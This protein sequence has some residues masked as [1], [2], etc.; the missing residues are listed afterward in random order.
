MKRPP[1][2]SARVRARA[3]ALAGGALALLA[4]VAVV[5]VWRSLLQRSEAAAARAELLRQVA[6]ATE[7]A[8]PEPGELSRLAALLAQEPER[9]E[10][11]DLLAAA[12][13]IELARQR[14]E[15]A[16]AL[17]G[18]RAATPGASP[19][20]QGLGAEILLQ[21]QQAGTGDATAAAGMLRQ[22]E[23]FALRAHEASG[24]PLD[25]LRAWQAASR[26]G[27]KEA[28]D[29]HR[30][31]LQRLAADSPAAR[32]AQLAATFDPSLPLRDLEALRAEFLRVPPELEAMRVLLVLQSGDVRGATAA[33]EAI[34]L[35]A[36]GVLTVRW[37]AALVF[38][39]AALAYPTDSAERAGWR[40]RRNHQL[41]WLLERAPADDGR[42]PQ[43]DRMR[44]ET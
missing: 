39:A 15:R 13:R 17:F 24:D 23:A 9:D 38:H 27:V 1:S 4:L 12:A 31:A 33:A 14:P 6:A 25:L 10:A 34:L 43:W 28:V 26:L 3:R 8:E 41:D 37:A 40:Q 5:L 32:L 30:D 42:R 35:R 19:I 36:P 7:R 18:T 20:E 11:A 44:G 21:L 2:R 29:R 22:A 16:Q